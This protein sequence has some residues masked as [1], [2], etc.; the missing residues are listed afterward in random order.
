MDYAIVIDGVPTILIEDKYAGE[1]L[2]KHGS[3]LL[4]YYAATSA[5]FGILTN[6]IEY[7][8]Y[9]DLENQNKMDEVPFFAVDLLDLKDAQIKELAKLHKSNF[10]TGKLFASTE[11]LKYTD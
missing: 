3:Q 8:F 9:I 5:K 2:D 11:E 4:R 6:G 7:R 1:N 10:Y